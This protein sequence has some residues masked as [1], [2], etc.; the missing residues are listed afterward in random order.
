MFQTVSQVL[1]KISGL[2]LSVTVS[3]GNIDTI[4]IWVPAIQWQPCY[5]LWHDPGCLMTS[6]SFIPAV[7]WQVF[8]GHD[9]WL[10][11]LSL[12]M[13][14]LKTLSINHGAIENIFQSTVE[15]MKTLSINLGTIENIFQS[16]VAPMTTLTTLFGG[17]ENSPFGLIWPLFIVLGLN[18][19][20]A[21]MIQ[22]CAAGLLSGM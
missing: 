22:T 11:F 21:G 3:P 2:C 19:I 1:N 13:A 8:I 7:Q 14:A 5:C 16:T 9:N 4:V 15:P 12:A 17:W 18:Q 20:W 10:R 6:L